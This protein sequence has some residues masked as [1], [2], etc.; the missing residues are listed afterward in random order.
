MNLRFSQ[1]ESVEGVDDRQCGEEGRRTD[2][3]VGLGSIAAAE[4][5]ELLYVGVAVVL[6]ARG[7][8][9]SDLQ[10]GIA[11]EL[12][13]KS[14]DAPAFGGEMGVV[15]ESLAPSCEMGDEGVNEHICGA[16]VE[17]E[18]LLR[19]G[20]RWKNRDVGDASEIERNAAELG[21]AIQEIVSV[22]DER[23]TL[24]TE[25]DVRR[26]KIADGGD[27]RARGDDRCLTSLKRRSCG[28]A[29]ILAREALMEDGL[30]VTA[31][32]RYF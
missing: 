5:E 26:A 11:Q 21:V 9:R 4:G 20:R 23:R 18:D 31:D 13:E 29:K 16:G 30:A 12:V 10:I 15:I 7:F 24:A 28:R 6:A 19:P 2:E 3:V 1:N 25:S 17:G 8:W 22:G 14:A 32:E 27:P